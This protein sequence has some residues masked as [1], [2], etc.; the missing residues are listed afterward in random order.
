MTTPTGNRSLVLT[1]IAMGCTLVALASPSAPAKAEVLFD[2]L[3]GATSG[4]SSTANGGSIDATF[5]TGGLPFD[6]TDIALEIG[7]TEGVDDSSTVVTVKL[8]G[9]IPLSSLSFDPI[10]GLNIPPGGEPL[11]ASYTIPISELSTGLTVEHSNA[12]VGISLKANSL[13]WVDLTS[14]NVDGPFVSW[15]STSDVSGVGVAENYNSSLATFLSFFPNQ[16]VPPFAIDFAY[17]MEVTGTAVPEPSTWAMMLL[18]FAGLGCAGYWA[19]R[20]TGAG[21]V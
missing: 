20:R 1:R 7:K 6:L 8:V 16:G 11:V 13:Y 18:G 12:F 3:G 10:F 19:S 5:S 4:S 15:A 14:S 17:K 21:A 2:S 9:G